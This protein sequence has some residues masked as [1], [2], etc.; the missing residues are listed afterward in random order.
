MNYQDFVADRRQTLLHA[1]QEEP[2][3]LLGGSEVPIHVSDESYAFGQDPNFYYLTGVTEPGCATL[4]GAE[5]PYELFLPK[6]DVKHRVWMGDVLD[7]ET[8]ESAFRAKASYLE[9][10]A[11]RLRSTLRGKRKLHV[12][13]GSADAQLDRVLAELR[14]DLPD[15]EIDEETAA[16]VLVEMR[17]IKAPIEIE[18]MRA[19]VAVT[20]EAFESFWSKLRPGVDEADVHAEL[21]GVFRRRGAVHSYYPIVGSGPNPACL[22]YRTNRRRM[23]AGEML[24]VDAG[25]ELDGYKSD[26]TRTVPVDGRWE[27]KRRAVYDV[28]LAAQ[29]QAV[30]DAQAGVDYA[31]LH[32]DCGRSLLAG[33]RD[34]GLVKGDLDG[35]M[36]RNVYQVFFPHGL[37]HPI[38]L[39]TH[40]VGGHPPGS[41]LP[42][43]LKRVNLRTNRP[44][45]AG[46]V[47]TIEP[48]IYFSELLLAT[49]R[50]HEDYR[51]AVDWDLAA[52]FLEV[53]GVRIEDDVLVTEDGP[54]VLTC[55]IAKDPESIPLG[56]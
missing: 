50:D 22:H 43:A 34:L 47:V 45:Q 1:L 4:I 2:V 6:V 11:D 20:R 42:P 52:S 53:G 54:V 8:A 23:N 3:F 29:K 39:E 10:L 27:G 51:D 37:G 33:L 16:R 32:V 13:R 7:V 46:M 18:M 28:V 48:G 9:N 21:D 19:A 30:E 17:L 49:S 14:S 38:G 41:E 5:V 56:A 44:L 40:D 26:V 25:A 31:E 35:L 24:L 15:L 36:E 12:V 55:D